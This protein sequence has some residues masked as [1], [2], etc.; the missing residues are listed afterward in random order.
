[1]ITL[2]RRLGPLSDDQPVDGALVLTI[3]Q[4]ER[5]RFRACLSNGEAVGVMLPRGGPVLKAGDGLAD[6]TGRVYRIEAA[7]EPVSTVRADN[8]LLLLRAAYHLGNRH[9]PLEV[10]PD[11]LRYRHDHVLDD[12]VRGLGL[13]P[14]REMAPFQPESGAYGHGSGHHHHGH[15]H[16]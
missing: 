10:T 1:M 7:P 12:M 16:A 5:S 4:R 6:E 2:I 13:D 8:P 3:E 11:W 15:S 9:T 14:V